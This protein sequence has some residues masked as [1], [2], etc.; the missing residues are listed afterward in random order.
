MSV[1]PASAG[2]HI[3]AFSNQQ[4]A[5]NSPVEGIMKNQ[6]WIT[7]VA[8][9]GAIVFLLCHAYYPRMLLNTP[10]T[11]PSG[12]AAVG[13]S[14]EPALTASPAMPASRKAPISMPP[15]NAG[16]EIDQKYA[17]RLFDIRFAIATRREGH[18][19]DFTSAPIKELER[20]RDTLLAEI[21]AEKEKVRK[22]KLVQKPASTETEPK[23]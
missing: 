8:V 2:T 1:C 11:A 4:S 14:A 10:A 12:Q 22:G 3:G 17:E 15:A 18:P 21:N 20:Q 19:D 23:R 13:D 16:D 6:K 5:N 7:G 9:V